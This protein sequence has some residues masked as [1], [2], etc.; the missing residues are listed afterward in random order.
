M[1]ENK[2]LTLLKKKSLIPKLKLT[3]LKNYI[4]KCCICRLIDICMDTFKS[5]LYFFQPKL[6]PIYQFSKL[7]ICLIDPI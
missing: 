1:R 2:V 5:N 7:S 4:K 6:L 3:N